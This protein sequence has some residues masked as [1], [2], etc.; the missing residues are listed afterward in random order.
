MIATTPT[1]ETTNWQSDIYVESVDT[2]LLCTQTQ[3]RELCTKNGTCLMQKGGFFGLKM[4]PS[5]WRVIHPEINAYFDCLAIY[6]T[7]D[8]IHLKSK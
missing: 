5:L 8:H 6:N 2:I 1:F 7:R 3:R 4:S